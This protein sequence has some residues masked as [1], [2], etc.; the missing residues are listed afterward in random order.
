MRQMATYAFVGDR[1]TV[2]AGLQDFLDT[3]GADELMAVSH[4]YDPLDK[5]RSYE[6]LAELGL[7][8]AE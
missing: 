5:L 8:K 2:K 4:L 7:T 1:E 3:T 6:L